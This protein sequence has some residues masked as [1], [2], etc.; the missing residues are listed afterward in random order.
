LKNIINT[1]CCQ[2]PGIKIRVSFVG[3]RDIGDGINEFS[4][5]GFTEDI[6]EVRRYIER[7]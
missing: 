1:T 5:K 2:F 4:I 3:Y 7:V 6:E